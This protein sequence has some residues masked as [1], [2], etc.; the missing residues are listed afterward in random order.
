[1]RS[2]QLTLAKGEKNAGFLALD[3]IVW[4]KMVGATFCHA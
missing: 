3:V 4:R 2:G 1:M